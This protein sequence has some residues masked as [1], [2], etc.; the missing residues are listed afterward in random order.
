[1]SQRISAEQ[2]DIP[3]NENNK[4]MLVRDGQAPFKFGDLKV[5]VIAPFAED[6]QK[7]REDWNDW[8]EANKDKVKELKA[9]ARADARDI[10]SELERLTMPLATD[11]SELGD[12]SLVTPPNLASIMLFV[13]DGNRQALLTG[14]GHA[15]DVIKGLETTGLMPPGGS[16]HIDVLKVPH[17]GSEHNMT[18]DFA[19][20]ITADHYIFCGNGFSGNPEPVVVDVLFNARVQDGA[21]PSRNFKFWFNS[22]KAMAAG[23]PSRARHMGKLETKVAGLMRQSSRLKSFFLQDGDHFNISLR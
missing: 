1:V 16:M 3:L 4:L 7:F 14:D 18:P 8:L 6:V 20:R 5:H 9:K 11:V 22:S 19:K 2:L 12:R 17:H 15:D 23:L 10:S 13:E 21:G